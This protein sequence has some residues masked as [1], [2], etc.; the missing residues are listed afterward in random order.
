[1]VRFQSKINNLKRRLRYPIILLVVFFGCGVAALFVASSRVA[2]ESVVADISRNVV[3][4]ISHLNKDAIP[5]LDRLKR[6]GKF[7]VPK[8]THYDYYL[9][10]KG[11]IA[12]WSNNQFVP[13]AA[14]VLDDFQF[15]LLKEGNG[16]YLATRWQ[17]NKDSFLIGV[18]MLSRSYPIV[19]DFLKPEWNAAIFPRGR[20]NILDA[21][22]ATGY[23]IC[24]G[25]QCPFRVDFEVE[26]LAIHATAELCAAVFLLLSII[27]A[28][29]LA[30]VSTKNRF[31][32][33]VTFIILAG[34]L[35]LSRWL[36]I[37]FDF[38]AA[39]VTGD[40]FN[41]GVFAASTLNASLGDLL[42]NEITLLVLCLYLFRN[43]FHFHVVIWLNK[44]ESTKWL[45]SV[46]SGFLG[47][48]AI[49]FPFVVVQTLYNN[50]SIP[51]GII[52]SLN[53]DG[54]RIAA[55]VAIVIAGACAFLFMHSFFR[56]LTGDRNLLRI[57]IC[58]VLSLIVF[59]GVNLLS[60]QS[61]LS[62]IVLSIFFFAAVLFL[63]LQGSLRRLTFS[64]FTYLFISLFFLSM[65][66]AYAMHV[67]S[68]K[69]KLN[70]Q[71]RFA[72]NFLIDRDYFGEY[73]LRELSQKISND[74]F[75]Q[76]RIATPFLT[77]DAVKQKI[78]Q[79]FLPSYFNRYD[80]EIYTFNAAGEASDD[81]PGVTTIS[82]FL[83]MYDH[84]AFKTEYDGVFY[85]NTPAVDV[86]Q[87]YLVVV[88]IS[89]MKSVVGQILIEFS[90][91]KVIPETVY[92]ELLVDNRFLQYYHF[93]EISY[94]VFT[95]LN[96]VSSYGDFNYETFDRRWFGDPDLHIKGL[97]RAGYDH[98]AEEDELGR[99]AVVSSRSTPI[100][101][102]VAN[103]SFLLVVGLGAILLFLLF[104]SALIFFH[105]GTLFLSTRI[106]LFLNLAFFLPLIIVS[107]MTLGLTSR[108]SEQQISQEYLDKARRFSEVVSETLST[109]DES[110]ESDE[111]LDNS[112]LNLAQLTNLDGS[113]YSPEGALLR[114]SQPLVFENKI[115]SEYIQP[116]ALANIRNGNSLF[117]STERIGDLEYYSAY[118]ALKEP[119]SGKLLG[120]LGIPFFQSVTSAERVQV[121]IL[122]N[123]LNIFALI[124]IVLIG[125]SYF[126]TRWLTFPLTFITQSLKKTSLTRANQP[127]VW[128]TDD[129]IGLMVKEYNQ[130]LYSLSESKAELEQ[131]Q[132]E[133]A[134]REIAQQVAHE[135]KNP[136]T[137]MKL[138]LQ[139]LERSLEAGNA[140]PDKI[141]K[142]VSSLLVQ[143]NTLNE[144]ASSF[145]AFA[146]MPEPV[147]KELELVSLLKRVTDLHS[148]SGEIRLEVTR[149][150]FHVKGDEQ[151][152]G[153]TF[154]NLILNALQAARPGEPARVIIRAEV[155]GNKALLQ[156][157]DNGK[158]ISADVAERIFVPHF[159]TKKSGSG[160]GLAISRQAIE[161]MHGRIW[162]ET[163]PGKGTTF[164]I[165][166]PVLAAV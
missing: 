7:V 34:T 123:I 79:V 119:S 6:D 55:S 132:R 98:V 89:W 95:N 106:Q 38:P 157:I 74:V 108:S 20:T 154:S 77:K 65:N 81:R 149:R 153:R 136:L 120:I 80:V 152:L 128:K 116:Q 1:V 133:R 145:S 56:L 121:S 42:L 160:L 158:G 118:A 76:S 151:L 52:D 91:K 99:M 62:S 11:R 28:L 104:Q 2:P 12:A 13:S 9:Y 29:W 143:V 26:A 37:E 53:F 14:S 161:Q 156:F 40:L 70:N 17:I 45:L 92:P 100:Q 30:Y 66:G 58:F 90:L 73:L 63:R 4:E 25:N 141:N 115:L 85:V 111:A 164:F 78:R 21:N 122:V 134:W 150:E 50:S 105:R 19:N 15:R 46:I 83:E 22:A 112:F 82:D 163:T 114:T 18:I 159:T 54:L 127:L 147:M 10:R 68:K 155:S 67:F 129:E 110:D 71:F 135:I 35:F 87:K 41:P 102:S 94:G 142:A 137:P 69:E 96:L 139:Q 131:T 165:E 47:T 51:L 140:G 86:S 109:A 162:F 146:K 57:V 31:V 107:I 61:F 93:E 117:I 103:F 125:L 44:K 16:G 60:G 8:G 124:F 39:F 64:T 130:M 32:P 75:I 101:Y 138:T 27:T 23:P 24:I 5:I 84:E 33:D 48:M 88:P 36:M 126:V 148:H 72:R 3:A 97:T 166:L 59:S 113:M 144:I 43:V 49:L